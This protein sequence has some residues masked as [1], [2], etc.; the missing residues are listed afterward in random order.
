MDKAIVMADR[1][2]PCYGLVPSRGGL[3]VACAPD[4]VFLK[5]EDGDGTAE[6]REKLF[7]GF[8]T[9][10]LERGINNPRWGIDNWIYFGG[11]YGGTITGPNLKE[12]VTL[13]GTDFRVKAD[14][15]AIEP[16]TGRTHTFGMTMDDHGQRW[17]I[18]TS[19]RAP[20]EQ[21]SEFLASTDGWFRPINLLAG[22]DGAI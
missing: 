22:P 1:L 18:T 16:V 21:A 10:N 20:E 12:A 13:G 7:T 19:R 4:I 17:L 2:P 14:G 3:I 6:I 11:S 9:G 5:D 15:S 8:K